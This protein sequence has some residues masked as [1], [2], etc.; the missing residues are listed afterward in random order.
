MTNSPATPPQSS[1]P[2][3]LTTRLITAVGLAILA[4]IFIVTNQGTVRVQIL[5]W[6]VNSPL[7]AL[8]LVLLVVGIAIGSLFPWLKSRKK[9]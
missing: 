7:W 5:V 1:R 6:A 8:I 2:A 4:V 9:N 3:W